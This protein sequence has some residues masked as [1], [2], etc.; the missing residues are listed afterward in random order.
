MAPYYGEGAGR[1][2]VLFDDETLIAASPG[3]AS[4]LHPLDR[5]MNREFFSYAQPDGKP[6]YH[7]ISLRIKGS[8]RIWVQVAFADNEVIF[9]SV[10]EEFVIDIA[11]IWIPFVIILLM[12]NMIVI[13]LSLKPLVQASQQAAQI[14]PNAVSQRLSEQDMP[15]EVLTLVSAINHA[16]DQLEEGYKRRRGVHRRRRA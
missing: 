6:A 11:W 1:F 10:L 14:G 13:R 2:A 12:I 15:R 16:L 8:P 9:N 4:A 3:V 5:D 7:G